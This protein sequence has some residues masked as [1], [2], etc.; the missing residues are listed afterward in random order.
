MKIYPEEIWG[1]TPQEVLMVFL[2]IADHN[3]HCTI[4]A[5]VQKWDCGGMGR[6]KD[7]SAS[8]TCVQGKFP[9]QTFSNLD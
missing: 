3:V 8:I 5:T 6:K 9:L 1:Y 7:F 2:W 4:Q